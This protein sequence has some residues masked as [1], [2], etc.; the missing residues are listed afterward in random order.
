M[1]KKNSK[2]Y[3]WLLYLLLFGI[4]AFAAWYTIKKIQEK[5]ALANT[6]A[7]YYKAFGIEIPDNYTI[8]GIDVSSH[9]NTIYWPMVKAMKVDSIK[10]GFVFIK[11]TEG[12][13]DTDKYF[14]SN[15]RNTTQVGL[16]HGA[17]HF[18][19]AT[20]SGEK[21]AH[22]FIKQVTLKSGDL[23]PVVDVEQ[24]YGVKPALLIQRLQACLDSLEH[25]YHTKPIIYTYVSFYDTYLAQNFNTY[26]LW[27]AH[28]SEPNQPNITRNW[29]FWQHSERG[30]INGITNFVDC[31]VFNGDSSRFHSL[32]VK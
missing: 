13:S 32:L 20:K 11:A 18:F 31:N 6:K 22:N 23:P 19:L 8:H 3:R 12:L 14:T 10:M 16:T 24:L 26:P 4:T 21:Q 15:W 7:T 9:Q 2:K 27:I 25:H 17:Y 28:Y 30:H 5:Q 29:L 1:A